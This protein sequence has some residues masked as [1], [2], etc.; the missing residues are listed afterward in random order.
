MT[1]PA[2][3]RQVSALEAHLGTRVVH[4]ST[5]AVTLT[6]EGRHLLAAARDLVTAAESLRESTADRRIHAVGVVRLAVQEGISARVVDHIPRLLKQHQALSVELVVR[7]RVGG[8]VEEGLDAEVRRGPIEDLT[9][10]TRHIG[11]VSLAVVASPEYLARRPLPEHPSDLAAHDCIIHGD[12]FSDGV[13]WFR[14]TGLVGSERSI[15]VTVTGR[16]RSNHL[17]SVHRTAL[18]GEG[19]ASLPSCLIAPDL[20]TGALALLLPRFERRGWAV[21]VAYPNRSAL[22]RRTRV[23]IDF[24]VDLFREDSPRQAGYELSSS[25]PRAGGCRGRQVAALR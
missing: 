23:I 1:Q 25:F 19:I 15:P 7:D 4:R 18:A 10:V 17:A 16:F 22:P 2:I 20:D 14:E 6:D 21:H 24:L 13:W 12:P 5:Q 9:V 3:S 8:L 11:S